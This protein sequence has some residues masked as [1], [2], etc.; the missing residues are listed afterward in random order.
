MILFENF[1]LKDI[2]YYKIGGKARFVLKIQNR[3]DL[4]EAL[5]FI[6][7]N[8]IKKTLMVGLGANLLV[9]DNFFDGAVLWFVKPDK[10][11][12]KQDLDGLVEVFASETLDDLIQFCFK[13]N[14]RG[15]E[16]AG[17][18]P[19][20]IGAAVRGNVGAFGE[21]IGKTAEKVEV[22]DMYSKLVY[23]TKKILTNN[24][25]K[26]S[27]RNSLI[28]DNKNLI[29]S[30]VFFKLSK[31]DKKGIEKAK[32]IYFKNIDYRNKHHPMEYPSC[33]SVF[34]NIIERRKIEA[35]LL[36]WPDI[37]GQVEDKWY[38]KAAMGYIIARL[39]LSSFRIGGA[40]VSEKRPNFIINF[41]HATFNDVFL[42]INKIKDRFFQEFSFYPE[43]EV[44]VVK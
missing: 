23:Y 19:S 35:I 14:L 6:K 2:L 9:S 26:F 27:Y 3:N 4:L 29:V 25:L 16:W 1:P 10:S 36:K 43:L 34:K 13:H 32:E 20:T 37:K 38:G 39:G 33:G 17:G 28:K 15:L 18:L 5:E 24:D 30:T 11:S 42:I 12:I 8:Q 22:C 41:N 31:T 44:E 21:E 7:K 40:K